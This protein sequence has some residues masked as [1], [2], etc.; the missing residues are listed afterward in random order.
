[1]PRNLPGND[2]LVVVP[3]EGE[4]RG[5]VKHFFSSVHGAEVSGPVLTPDNTAL[6]AAVL[7]PAEGSSFAQPSTRWPGGGEMPPRPPAVVIT[8]EGAVARVG[9]PRG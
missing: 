6:A 2:G 5:K 4:E 7:H 8:T 9:A 1:M 3:A